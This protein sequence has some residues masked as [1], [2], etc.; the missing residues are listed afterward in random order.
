LTTLSEAKNL[1]FLL[2]DTNLQSDIDVPI[3]R[4]NNTI[5]QFLDIPKI[6]NFLK[7][8]RSIFSLVISKPDIIFI[9]YCSKLSLLYSLFFNGKVILSFWGGD[10]LN[11]TNKKKGFLLRNIQKWAII[12][13]HKVFCVS[14]ELIEE[15][16]RVTDNQLLKPPCLLMYGLDLK[17]YTFSNNEMSKKN[18]YFTIYSPRWCLPL[19]NIE[20]IIDA[21]ILLLQSGKKV[22]LIYRDIYIDESVEAY[23]YSIKLATKIK[24]SGFENNFKTVRKVEKNELINLIQC[25]DVVISVSHFDGTPLSI[26]EAM[27]CKTLT[28]S[29]KIPSTTNF[30]EDGINGYL[31]DKDNPIEIAQQLNFILTNKDRQIHIIENARLFV[32]THANID[33]EVAEYVRVINEI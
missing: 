14:K 10:L 8:F 30:I 31:V 22:R 20:V 27:A 11:R 9:M 3:A 28:L 18:E 16:Y 7:L 12:K 2:F 32:E 23:Q 29:G 5:P 4:I 26:L 19:Y 24:E 21:V 33:L 13:S 25:S 15:V 17:L 1:S 6:G